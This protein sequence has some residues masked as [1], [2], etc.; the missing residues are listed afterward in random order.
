MSMVFNNASLRT[1]YL[2]EEFRDIALDGSGVNF[3]HRHVT[4]RV[5]SL[6]LAPASVISSAI[7]TVAGL[8]AGAISLLTLGLEKR[9]V[10]FAARELSGTGNLISKPVE[11]LLRTINPKASFGRLYENLRSDDINVAINEIPM[12]GAVGGRAHNLALSKNIFVRH[13]VA[14]GAYLATGIAAVISRVAL[15]VLAVPAVALSVATFGCVESINSF[16]SKTL[17]LPGLV[18]DLFMCTVKFINPWAG[19]EK[20]LSTL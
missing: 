19:D 20:S 4:A 2:G 18:N 1:T 16:A 11:F 13:V 12:A 6:L 7:D 5:G 3:V 14:R 15:A 8:A 17:R 9:T 10:N